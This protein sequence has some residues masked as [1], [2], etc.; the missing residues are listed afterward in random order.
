MSDNK[1]PMTVWLA[2]DAVTCLERNEDCGASD[3]KNHHH[4]IGPYVNLGQFMEEV[5]RRADAKHATMMRDYGSDFMDSVRQLA[6][7]MQ[8]G[9]A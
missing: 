4:K 2:C 6:R 5:D 7:E 8:E 3:L 9:K 1:P